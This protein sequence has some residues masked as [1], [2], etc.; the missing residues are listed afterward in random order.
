MTT[1]RQDN[2]FADALIPG[3]DNLLEEAIE[4]IKDNLSVDQVFDDLTTV[5]YVKANIEIDQV[6]DERAI[7]G[8]IQDRYSPAE[9]FD[10]RDLVSWADDNGFTKE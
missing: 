8:H 10:H 1:S 9:A 6:F 7:L 2:N 3:R 4:W 5:A